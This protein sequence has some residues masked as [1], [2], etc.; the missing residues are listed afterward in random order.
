MKEF[1]DYKTI[2]T[3]AGSVAVTMLIVEF[4]KDLKPFRNIRTKLLVFIIGF[5]LIILT[6]TL[7]GDFSIY[8]LPLYIINS[9]LVATTA[10]GSWHTINEN[11]S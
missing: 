7:Q 10:I 1:F 5:I 8:N 6:S 9:F 11:N 2:G 3:L 4:I